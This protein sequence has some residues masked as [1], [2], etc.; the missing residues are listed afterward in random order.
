MLNADLTDLVN[1]FLLPAS[2]H[3]RKGLGQ[4]DQF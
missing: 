1:L 4:Q 2:M 3:S